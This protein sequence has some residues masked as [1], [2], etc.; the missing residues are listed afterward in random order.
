MQK[1]QKRKTLEAGGIFTVRKG[2]SLI[3]QTQ[4]RLTH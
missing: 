1:K 2:S 4:R 3:Q